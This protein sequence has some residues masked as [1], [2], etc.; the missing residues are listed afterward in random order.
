MTDNQDNFTMKKMIALESID[1]ELSEWAKD[2][3]DATPYG[4]SSSVPTLDFNREIYAPGQHP[5]YPDGIIGIRTDDDFFI[6]AMLPWKF[7]HLSLQNIVSTL[8]P[9]IAQ[10]RDYTVGYDRGTAAELDFKGAQERLLENSQYALRA[11]REVRNS[12]KEL[13]QLSQNAQDPFRYF[14]PAYTKDDKVIHPDTVMIPLSSIPSVEELS[15]IIKCPTCTD[16]G[17]CSGAEK[18]KEI[19]SLIL[20]RVNPDS[21][22]IETKE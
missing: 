19:R 14:S 10:T 16:H 12:L 6:V 3:L 9:E 2:K 7:K 4:Y 1:L 8:W 11:M 22:P 17:H 18:A 15:A 21:I 20:G 13:K 5:K